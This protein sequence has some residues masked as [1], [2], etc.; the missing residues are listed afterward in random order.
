MGLPPQKFL[1]IPNGIDASRYP[2][3]LADLRTFGISPGRRAVVFVG[4]LES[5][6]GVRWLIETAPLW[7]A[8]LPDCDLLMVGDGPLRASLEVAVQTAGVGDRV[9][10]A[11]W[12]PDVHEILAASNLLVLPSAWEGMPNVVLEAMATRLPVIASDVEGVRELLGAAPHGKRLA[13][14]IRKSLSKNWLASCPTKPR[15]G[16]S[17]RKTAIG[18]RSALKFRGWFKPTKPFGSRSR[19]AKDRR[20]NNCRTSEGDSP[21]FVERKLGQSPTYWVLKPIFW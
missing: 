13:L 15:P 2:A 19:T 4:R 12:R 18:S 8:K 9:F 7:L 21:I 20:I 10:F 6:K 11:G 3:R 1:V 17:A 14:A 16:P 5:Q